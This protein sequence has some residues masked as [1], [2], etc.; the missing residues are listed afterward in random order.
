MGTGRGWTNYRRWLR[1]SALSDRSQTSRRTRQRTD[2]TSAAQYRPMGIACTRTR[3]PTAI[4][5]WKPPA[6]CCSNATASSFA[7]CWRAKPIS[8]SGGN[9]KWLSAVWK[10]V[11]RFAADALWTAFWANSSHCRSQWSRCARPE[12]C[13]NTG[14]TI[15]LS[16]ADPLNLV[17]ILV[18]GERFPRSR[19]RP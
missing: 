13:R 19:E 2:G 7:I 18:P 1:Q 8:P 10:I 3:R 12:K 9:C 17:G 14:E 16:A 15:V 4:A 5:R 6:G 11:A